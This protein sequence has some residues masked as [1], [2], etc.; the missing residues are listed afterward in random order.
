MTE[1]TTLTR[2]DS[3][4]ETAAAA[5]AGA[6]VPVEVSVTVSDP[7]LAYRR[8]RTADRDGVFL[9]TTGGQSGWGY[10]AVAP[11][12]RVE[13]AAGEGGSDDGSPSI[14]AIDALLER[15]RLVRGDCDV[16]YPCGAFGWLSYDVARE[17]EDLQIG[18]AHV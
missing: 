16:P 17:L 15:E 4:V 18:R 11:V 7:F 9:E 1:P 14:E 5:P 10:F 2:K 8:A 12:E 3:F 13:V 6:R